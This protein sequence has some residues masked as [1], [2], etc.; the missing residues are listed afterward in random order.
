[1]A[2]RHS[3]GILDMYSVIAGVIIA[4]IAFIKIFALSWVPDK[5]LTIISSPLYLIPIIIFLAL[6]VFARLIISPF[7]VYQEHVQKSKQ[8]ESE[9]NYEIKKQ[10]E[11]LYEKEKKK[12]IKDGLGDLLCKAQELK[13]KC[14]TPSAI[15]SEGDIT[16]WY[17]EA[18]A[19]IDMYLG[20]S[21]LGLFVNTTNPQQYVQLTETIL[22]QYASFWSTLSIY[23][24]NIAEIVK[25]LN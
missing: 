20:K 9:L 4:L 11:L 15:I 17:K 10:Q 8:K 2:F 12:I 13:M 18:Y 7:W 1:M 19:F 3:R 22:P 23:S 16:K 5:W 25:S 24:Y 14:R 21:E 6:F